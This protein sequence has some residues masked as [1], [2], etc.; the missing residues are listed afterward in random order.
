MC[1]LY[2]ARKFCHK[3]LFLRTGTLNFRFPKIRPN[4]EK[5][6]KN[7]FF[8]LKMPARRVANDAV[9]KETL[10]YSRF[11]I[12]SPGNSWRSDFMGPGSFVIGVKFMVQC[13]LRESPSNHSVPAA[14]LA[15][16]IRDPAFLH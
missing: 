12:N 6:P 16:A 8:V 11:F 2:F 13:W 4:V 5:K 1:I 15:K 9:L 7:S 10:E 3:S 14:F